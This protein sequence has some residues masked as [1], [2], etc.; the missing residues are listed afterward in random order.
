LAAA[1]LAAHQATL[2]LLVVTHHSAR[3]HQQVAVVVLG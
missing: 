2:E 3:L 1:V